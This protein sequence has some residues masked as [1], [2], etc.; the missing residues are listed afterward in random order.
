IVLAQACR[1]MA[2]EPLCAD[3]RLTGIKD[4][5]EL[6][7]EALE[8][9]EIRLGNPVASIKRLRTALEGIGVSLPELF[10]A[11]ERLDDSLRNLV[12]STDA[13]TSIARALAQE[14][15]VASAQEVLLWMEALCNS[16]R[17]HAKDVEFVFPDS[18]RRVLENSPAAAQAFV[19]RPGFSMAPE[20]FAVG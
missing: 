20:S 17:S 10:S 3:H 15:G 7:C 19:T 12:A 14:S 18:R 5:F 11:R 13:A 8:T 2:K 6:A 9:L 1:H 4:N 16:V